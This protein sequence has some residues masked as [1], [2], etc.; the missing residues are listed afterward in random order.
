MPAG[1]DGGVQRASIDVAALT[2]GWPDPWPNVAEIASVLPSDRWTL[3][4]GLMT[5][6]HCIHHG[7]GVVRPTNDVDIVLHV[8]TTRG[9]ASETAAALRSL[10]YELRPAST[11]G[12]TPLIASSETPPRST[13]S[14]AVR[15]RTARR[16]STSCS[17][18]TTLPVSPNV[19]RAAR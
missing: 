13:W 10:G 6:L 2:G 3:I 14:P 18:T 17:P 9:V 8:E 12:T 11:P 4:G 7:L 15:T 5:Q 16:S 19:S 1:E